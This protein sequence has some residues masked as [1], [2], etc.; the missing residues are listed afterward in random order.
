M[1]FLKMVLTLTSLAFL[2]FPLVAFA[3]DEEFR[4][5]T[6]SEIDGVEFR[7]EFRVDGDEVEERIEFG[8]E[9]FEFKTDGEEFEVEG[10]VGEVADSSFTV[11]FSDDSFVSVEVMLDPTMVDEFDVDGEVV[12]GAEVEAEGVV[13]DGANFAEEVEVEDADEADDAD[14]VDEE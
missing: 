4:S 2:A 1:N 12:V 8:D 14:D 11:G 10:M 7:S 6:R 5:E 9:E 13:I 3:S